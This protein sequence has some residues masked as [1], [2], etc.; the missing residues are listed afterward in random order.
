MFYSCYVIFVGEYGN[1]QKSIFLMLERSILNN[2]N[3][4]SSCSSR[5]DNQKFDLTLV[6]NFLEMSGGASHS[7]GIPNSEASLVTTLITAP[8]AGLHKA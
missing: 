3:I 2:C 7:G 6:Q 8:D 4:L 1:G 5:Q